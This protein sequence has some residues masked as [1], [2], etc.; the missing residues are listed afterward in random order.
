MIKDTNGN[1][2]VS[3]VLSL[4]SGQQYEF[5]VQIT[6]PADR[7]LRAENVAN[8]TVEARHS[9]STSYTN[10]ET[11]EIA[12]NPWANTTTTF[13]IRLTAGVIQIYDQAAFT[14]TV[15]L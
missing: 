1:E 7:Y 11:G 8:V 9:D 15:S 13:Y 10:I 12:L 14:I 6:C 3:Q 5:A 2:L 4:E